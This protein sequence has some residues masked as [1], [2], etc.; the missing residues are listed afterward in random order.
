MGNGF[1]LATENFRAG[2]FVFIEGQKESRNF[3]IIRT[4]KVQMVKEFS[5][6]ENNKPSMLT[7]GDFFGVVSCMSTHPRI[8]SAKV[9]TDSVLISIQRDQFGDLIQKI[10][11][12]AIKI[13]T[14]FSKKLRFFDSEITRLT[15]K[16]SMEEDPKYLYN[17]GEYYHSQNQINKAAYS[18]QQFLKFCPADPNNSQA[19]LKLQ[20]MNQPFETPPVSS[21]GL[22]REYPSDKM[23]F[24][25]HEPGEDLY[26][27][28]QGKVKITKIINNQEVLLA[29]LQQGDIFGEMAILEN[30]PRSASA[31]AYGD[32]V[33]LGVNKSNFESM[34]VAKPQIA[35]KLIQ[36]LSERIW[37]AY[38]Q[39]ENLMLKD[40]VGRMWD[41]LLNQVLKQRIPIEHRAEYSFEFGPS[42]LIKM[43][44]F[45]T[46]E[47]NIHIRKMFENRKISE[48]NGKIHVSDL[49]ELEKQVAYFKKIQEMEIKREMAARKMG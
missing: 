38:K 39:L 22:Q 19:K 11:P 3:Y 28:Q 36:L 20:Q 25:E 42:E 14:S 44:G 40:P 26:I 32:A 12:I 9:M 5:V 30:K 27:I 16:Q 41:T 45:S 29:V 37:T 47:G 48:I 10:T 24:S 2:S 21:A 18:F 13:I 23:I 17:I 8:E 35:T 4:G 43:V 7:N 46:D 33:L 6:V 15:L 31:I 34:V 1:K 49:E